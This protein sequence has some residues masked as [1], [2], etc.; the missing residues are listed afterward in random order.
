[1]SLVAIPLAVD[2]NKVRMVFGCKDKYLLE[3]VKTTG[4]YHSYANQSEEFTIP[5]Y[6]Y[7]FDEALEDIFFRYIK[8]EDRKAHTGFLR[9]V[10]SKQDSGLRKDIAHG[11][12]YALLVICDYFGTQLL[13]SFEGFY[14]GTEF[15]AAVAITKEKGLALDLNDIFRQHEVF[16][17]PPIGDSPAIKLFTKSEIA[18]VNAVMKKIKVDEARTDVEKEGFDQVQE[19]L[20][21]IRDSFRTCEEKGLEMI[22]F[23]H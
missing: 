9:I 20:L 21:F 10:R 18:Q 16:D 3:A 15:E 6:Q 2:I 11:Y 19:M 12:G 1:M 13:P 7:D 4:L 23:A 5:R 8:P 17:I 14:Y 22:S